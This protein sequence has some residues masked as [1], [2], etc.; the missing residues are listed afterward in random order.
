MENDINQSENGLKKIDV[1]DFKNNKK[2][3][4]S[5]YIYRGIGIV[6]F[7]AIF[8]LITILI[9]P[10]LSITLES[11]IG[12][13]IPKISSIIS[14][15]LIILDVIFV[16]YLHEL[17]H[18]LVFFI[19]NGQ[20]PKIGIRGFII[21][22]AAPEKLVKH[23]AMIINALSPFITISVIGIILISVLP[24]GVIPWIFIPT[25]INAAASGGDFM[26]TA[27]I[28]KHKSNTVYQDDGDI[29][30]AYSTNK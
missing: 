14:I 6:V 8:F 28:I 11:F 29:I 26:I 18:A 2:Q 1:I 20:K 24:T 15:I 23:N 17:I 27:W 22:A 9:H 12:L 30:T 19:S 10:N 25:V 16:L 4:I 13:S 7:G 3:L 21:F 5:S